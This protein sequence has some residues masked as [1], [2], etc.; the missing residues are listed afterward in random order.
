M[1]KITTSIL[2]IQLY[3]D[4]PHC[5]YLIDLLDEYDTDGVAHNDE[6][7]LLK[8]ACPQ[9][10]YWIDSHNTFELDEVT[11]SACKNEFSVRGIEW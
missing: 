2:D 8:V 4:C 1:T 10:G 7:D 11:C 6:G 3:V 9:Q 5:D